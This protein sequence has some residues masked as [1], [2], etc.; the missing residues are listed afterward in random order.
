MSVTKNI[1][2]LVFLICGLTT[3]AQLTL[4]TNLVNNPS[5]E[6][7]Y[8]CPNA[9]GQL[10]E[11]KY[12][13][14]YST[15]YFNAC[16][17]QGGLS[18][19][20][21]NFGS[22]NAHTGVAY[23]GVG[24]YA[25]PMIPEYRETIKT[26][27]SDSLLSNKR[28]C[29]KFYV[30]IEEISYTWLVNA[31]VFLDSIGMLFTKDSVPDNTSPILTNGII[32]QNDIFNIDTIS[33][34]QI[35]NSFIA[36]GGEQYLT[37]GNFDNIINFPSGKT[38]AV[39]IYVDDVSVCECAYKIN[40][41]NDT[42]LCEGET[43][44]L[45]PN[46]T[47]VTCI[48][49]DGSTDNNYTVT[50]AGTYWVQVY[51]PE[52]KITT[53]DTIIISYNPKPKINLGKDTLLCNGE[54]L[55]LNATYPNAVYKWQNTSTFP[56]FTATQEGTYWVNITDTLTKCSSI[57]TITLYCIPEP[58]IPNI[59]TPNG[60]GINDNFVIKNIEYWKINL[61]VFNRWGVIVYE[62]N[63]YKNNW[64]GKFTGNTLTDGTYFYIIKAKG[65]DSGKEKEYKG[66][67]MIM[68]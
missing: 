28:Y 45:S 67:L 1:V 15:E 5:F 35:S 55:I 58:V 7:Y 46:Q 56:T 20:L 37:I 12:W 42:T 9:P 23:A 3:K 26:K 57:A 30:S 32:V 61:Q 11:C 16:A 50:H 2:F 19:P 38:G 36:N 34:T 41:G 62:D 54:S 63:N 43:L 8:N 27:L 59:F 65:I 6:E 44:M 22:Q 68:R 31:N 48:W 64:D 33:W 17:P 18:V 13:W 66:S 24:I 40:L 10:Y 29:T 52:Y 51:Y 21:N 39:G 60:D 53:S 4:G 47:N 14:G 25:Y 49:Q